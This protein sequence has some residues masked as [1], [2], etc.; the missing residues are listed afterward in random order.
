[1]SDPNSERAAEL[2]ALHPWLS[3]VPTDGTWVGIRRGEHYTV[4]EQTA[5]KA[6]VA[7]AQATGTFAETK[8]YREYR[9]GPPLGLQVT[10]ATTREQL[11]RARSPRRR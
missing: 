1:M 2:L 10:L 7:Y 11:P 9:G 3:Q 4:T 6:L 8:T 5:R